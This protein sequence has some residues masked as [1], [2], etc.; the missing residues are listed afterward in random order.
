MSKQA[1]MWLLQSIGDVIIGLKRRLRLLFFFFL[2]DTLNNI[3]AKSEP[4]VFMKLFF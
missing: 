3:L 2:N 4:P 1:K